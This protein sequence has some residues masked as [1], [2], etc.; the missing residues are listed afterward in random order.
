MFPLVK[1]SQQILNSIFVRF[2]IL[3]LGTAFQ[4]M[5]I[6]IPNGPFTAPPIISQD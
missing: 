4:Q 6:S 2:S 3:F 5:L 1:L